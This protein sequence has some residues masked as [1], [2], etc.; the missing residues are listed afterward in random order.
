MK[1]IA[2]LSFIF[3]FSV[4]AFGQ[5]MTVKLY[6][7][8]D[9]KNPNTEDCR[10]VYPVTRKIPKTK[11]VAFA[12]LQELFK[13]V[14]SAEEQQGFTSFS[15]ESTK[16]ILKSVN[17]VNKAAYINFSD[18]V[19]QQLGNATTSCGGAYFFSSLERTLKQFPTIKKVF[20]AI[21]RNPAEFYEWV[22][23]GECPKELK[24]CSNKNF[25]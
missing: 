24:N 1:F 17:I 12:A 15:P 23:V 10:L 8:N 7:G 20:Y 5:T 18:A 3:A 21:E 22:Q 9:I 25:R 6:F 16:G 4:A 11:A 19:Y 14:T 13:G 2:V